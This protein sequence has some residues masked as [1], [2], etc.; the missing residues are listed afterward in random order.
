M[1]Y[2]NDKFVGKRGCSKVS[3]HDQMF[4][5]GGTIKY[6]ILIRFRI[7]GVGTDA[8]GYLPPLF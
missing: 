8:R 4:R 6:L 5:Q 7:R 2:E 1:F 3:C